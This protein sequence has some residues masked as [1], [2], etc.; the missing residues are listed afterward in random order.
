MIDVFLNMV[1]L[2]EGAN[3][4]D[5][6]DE[7]G[8]ILRTVCLLFV[9]DGKATILAANSSMLRPSYSAISSKSASF[10]TAI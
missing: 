3:E 9:G 8:A 10:S 5:P 2:K 1:D 6:I 7:G 4:A